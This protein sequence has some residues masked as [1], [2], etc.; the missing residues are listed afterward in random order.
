MSQRAAKRERASQR[1]REEARPEFQTSPT[2]VQHR[3]AMAFRTDFVCIK[4]PA[5]HC[6]QPMTTAATPGQT[7]IRYISRPRRL[8]LPPTR[9]M[10]ALLARERS[11]SRMYLYDCRHDSLRSWLGSSKA[12]RAAS[13]DALVTTDGPPSLIQGAARRQAC[14]PGHTTSLS[15]AIPPMAPNTTTTSGAT[16]QAINGTKPAVASAKSPCVLIAL[17]QIGS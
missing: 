9:P 16:L 1:L 4:L 14:R 13:L 6:R 2:K 3:G 8:S 12:G 17:V 5:L 10:A 7:S 11:M 15:S